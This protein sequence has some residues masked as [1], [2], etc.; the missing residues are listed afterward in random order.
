VTFLRLFWPAVVAAVLVGAAAPAIGTFVVQRRLSLI[1]DGVG[2]M[3]FAGVALGLWWGISPLAAALGAAV[4][5]ALGIDR[6]R[7]RAPS[8]ADLFLALFFYASIALAVVVASRTGSFNVRLFG[9]L[10]GQLLTVSHAELITIAAL[11]V[12]VAATVA[13]LYRG[14]A[15]SAIDEEAAAVAGVPVGAL[16]N[17]LMALTALA[18]GVGMQVVGILLIAALMVLPVGI[19]RNLV[20]S[21]RAVV[22]TSAAIGAVAAFGG[23]LIANAADT[24]ASGTIVL[25]LA[26]AF[27]VSSIPA[28]TRALARAPASEVPQS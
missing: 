8:E 20:R 4:L 15:A 11:A 28:A 2:H 3:A 9:F 14:L 19:A 16:N 13:L 12:A 6:L 25:L 5:G 1:G 27:V 22:L 18:V 7:R 17:V 26:A 10:F 21:L 23:L 24:A